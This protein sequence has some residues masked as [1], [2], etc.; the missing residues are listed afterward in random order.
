MRLST[1]I[2]SQF[3]S[4]VAS[5]NNCSQ[6]N[7]IVNQPRPIFN[8][9]FQMAHKKISL[10]CMI[11][12]IVLVVWSSQHMSYMVVSDIEV[13]TFV[14]PDSYNSIG[15]G[16]YQLRSNSVPAKLFTF[17]RVVDR[18]SCLT[19]RVSFYFRYF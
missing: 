7:P 9:L 14:H 1:S 3:I 13:F 10:N 19:K 8:K 11:G 12:D 5:S 6:G 2:S 18:E 4:S 15:L 17:A 16:E